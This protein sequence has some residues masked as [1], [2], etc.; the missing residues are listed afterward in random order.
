MTAFRLRP[1][2]MAGPES[3]PAP[4]E[5]AIILQEGLSGGTCRRSSGFRLS[6][7]KRQ[8][9]SIRD[10]TKTAGDFAG[11]R[12]V[13]RV[14]IVNREFTGTG[15]QAFPF[16]SQHSAG[17]NCPDDRVEPRPSSRSRLTGCA[18]GGD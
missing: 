18:S 2:G 11:V 14:T 16:R 17:T 10:D 4:L 7:P 3:R 12:Q 6:R 5:D 1:P 8:R 15:L 13:A 9:D